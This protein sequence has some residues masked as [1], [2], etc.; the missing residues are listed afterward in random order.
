MARRKSADTVPMEG[1]KHENGDREIQESEDQRGEK[2][3]EGRAPLCRP[4]DHR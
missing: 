4:M 2:R 3:E 1:V